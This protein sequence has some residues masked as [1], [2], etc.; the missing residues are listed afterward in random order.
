[1]PYSVEAGKAYVPRATETNTSTKSGSPV[2]ATLTLYAGWGGAVPLSF[3]SPIATL[4]FGPG[5][6]KAVDFGFTVSPACTAGQTG[7]MS[8]DVLSPL[9]AFLATDYDTLTVLGAPALVSFYFMLYYPPAG[10]DYWLPYWW[11][12][13]QWVQDPRGW[14]SS[15]QMAWFQ[16]VK[17]GPGSLG[18]YL[19]RS[20]TAQTSS[21]YGPFQLPGPQ[22]IVPA[23]GD[24]W[25]Y[26]FRTGTVYKS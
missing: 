16:N 25:V 15:T 26:D 5:E 9:G 13:T 21:F 12:G 24:F 18:F 17:P 3:S 20:D 8:V 6:T 11:D 7:S 4:P 1:M 23:N 14:I 2:G 10:W 22:G 19:W